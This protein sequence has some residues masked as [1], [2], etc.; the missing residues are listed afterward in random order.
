MKQMCLRV[1]LKN[2]HEIDYKPKNMVPC[3]RKLMRHE[4]ILKEYM[5][6]KVYLRVAM[7]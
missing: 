2:R 6:A 5:L 7:V 4:T 3:E 1:K